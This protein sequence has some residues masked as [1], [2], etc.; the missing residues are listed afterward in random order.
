MHV[1]LH[2]VFGKPLAQTTNFKNAYRTLRLNEVSKAI[3]SPLCSLLQ[4]FFRFIV[5]NRIAY[6]L[7][8]VA[9]GQNVLPAQNYY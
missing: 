3:I 9:I 4:Q 1:D 6:P 2:N 8:L 7:I 5:W